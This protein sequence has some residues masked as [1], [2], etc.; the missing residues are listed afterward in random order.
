MIDVEIHNF[1]S[2]EHLKVQIEG[3]TAV[4]GRSNLG[5]SAL[6]RA[7]KAALTGAQEDN[8]VR[9]GVTCERIVKSTKS[10]KCSCSVHIKAEG[11]DLLWEK[12]GD[13]NKYTFNGEVKTAVGK[14]T[15]EFLEERFGLVKIGDNKVLLQVA[16][17]FKSEGGGP[18][19]LLDE[20]GSVVADVLS[21][22][23]QLDRINVAMRMAEKDRR[24]ATAQRKLREKDVLELRIKLANYDNLDD[25]LARAKEVE[26]DERQVT[27]QRA[28]RDQLANF[29]TTFITVAR[30]VK[31]LNEVPK[32]VIPEVAPTQ[33]H[34]KKAK[35]LAGFIAEVTP[36]QKIVDSLQGIEDVSAPKIEPVQERWKSLSKLHG[37][38]L[39]FR[40]YKDL[41]AR[42][43]NVEAAP[44]P[45]IDEVL[46]RSASALKMATLIRRRAGLEQEVARLAKLVDEVEIEFQGI[47]VEK[48][49]LGGVCPTCSQPMNL[50]HEHAAA[51]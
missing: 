40:T 23:A 46:N 21:D 48:A 39:R 51:E 32:L 28:K 11:F 31:A 9:H 8:Y 15:P 27:N 50:D 17:Q 41:F 25:A 12:G 37:W 33:E 16:D 43:K 2:I 24:E 5:K 18:I 22:V 1:Q 13:L 29:R 34:Q 7:L 4:I 6:V 38:V 26:Q 35:L 20:S 3:F 44:V 10:C 45:T 42:W 36:R 30:R 19:F 49:E 14:G 47:L